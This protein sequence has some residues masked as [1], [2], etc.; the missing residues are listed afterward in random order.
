MG[1]K[2]RIKMIRLME[3]LKK[4]CFLG[5]NIQITVKEKRK[6]NKDGF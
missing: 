5:A 1:T 4:E 6:D 2:T 3:K